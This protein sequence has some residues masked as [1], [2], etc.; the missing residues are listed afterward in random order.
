MADAQGCGL[1]DVPFPFDGR[2]AGNAEDEV[3][4]D[5][6]ESSLL[7]VPDGLRRLPG[8]VA[9]SQQ[10]QVAV[11]EGLY[12]EAD[13]VDV[14]GGEFVEKGGGDVVGVHLGGDLGGGSHP[15]ERTRL[16]DEA[17]E[18]GGPVERR[19]AAAEKYRFHR[20]AAEVGV[21]VLHLPFQCF[22]VDLRFGAGGTFVEVAVVAAGFAERDVDVE[23]GH[24][25]RTA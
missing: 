8:V 12:A 19:G 23:C 11:Y 6:V 14:G 17:L 24:G 5:V 3:E 10:P 4:G 21:A 2:H 9:P 15:P 25:G 7:H 13:P 22:D 18:R 16:V 20:I 1:A